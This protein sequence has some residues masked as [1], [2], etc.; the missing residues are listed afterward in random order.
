VAGTGGVVGRGAGGAG[1]RRAESAGGLAGTR[2]VESAAGLGG[3]GLG[4][5]KVRSLGCVRPLS[6]RRPVAASR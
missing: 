6:A 3:G 2:A 4:V 1:T 5:E